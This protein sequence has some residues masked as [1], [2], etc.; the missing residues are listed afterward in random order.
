MQ[1]FSHDCQIISLELAH[2]FLVAHLQ[3]HAHF[4]NFSNTKTNSYTFFSSG[5]ALATVSP[6]AHLLAQEI[7]F[8]ALGLN[9]EL[10]KCLIRIRPTIERNQTQIRI[11]KFVSSKIKIISKLP[12]EVLQNFKELW[13]SSSSHFVVHIFLKVT[14]IYNL[15]SVLVSENFFQIA[16]I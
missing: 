8:V 14:V 9:A 15:L 6:C 7:K 10:S 11:L 12:F 2:I 4:L 5:S 1:T 3:L 13:I 16:N